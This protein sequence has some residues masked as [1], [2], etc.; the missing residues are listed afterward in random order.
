MAAA[1]FVLVVVRRV[2]DSRSW[3]TAGADRLQTA[4]SGIST[5]EAE[6]KIQADA[7]RANGAA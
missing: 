6:A 2:L 4:E 1:G 7:E 3:K 5:S